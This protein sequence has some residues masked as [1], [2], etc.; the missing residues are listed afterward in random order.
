[1]HPVR[2]VRRASL[3]G[4]KPVDDL[5]GSRTSPGFWA[6]F[7]YFG[8][9]EGPFFRKNATG[10]LQRTEKDQQLG[11]SRGRG[12]AETGRGPEPRGAEEPETGDQGAGTRDASETPRRQRSR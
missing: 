9:K 11:R 3:S 5:R 8:V 1:M 7:S 4:P 2:R 12:G 10:T 6:R